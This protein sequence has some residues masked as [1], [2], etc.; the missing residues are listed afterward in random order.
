VARLG[1]MCTHMSC[2]SLAVGRQWLPV[3]F[4]LGYPH[5]FVVSFWVHDMEGV[6]E[7]AITVVV[8]FAIDLICIVLFG[9]ILKWL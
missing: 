7:K 5:F 8:I 1:T 2:P 3:P 4:D 6:K 9:L